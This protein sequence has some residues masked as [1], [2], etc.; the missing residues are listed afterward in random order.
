MK[1]HSLI[2]AALLTAC[3][4]LLHAQAEK[5]ADSSSGTVIIKRTVRY[6]S[7]NRQDPFI[8]LELQKQEKEK[9][10]EAKVI[11]VPSL[12]ERQRLQPG[13]R[14]M[15]IKELKLQG[16][17][18]RSGEKVAFFQGADNKAHFIRSGDELFNAKVKDITKDAVI[19][20]EYK[21]FIN[22]AVET[23]IVTVAL[24]ETK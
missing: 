24:H 21:R 7:L 12:E 17:I 6:D 14:G 5:T 13:V 20:E 1:K 10:E 2:A 18:Q 8:N 16:I 15:L 22:K 11:P 23:T 19:F 9:Q 4:A 3:A